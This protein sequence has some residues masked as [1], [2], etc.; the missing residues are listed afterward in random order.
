MEADYK[1]FED[2]NAVTCEGMP[3]AEASARR[4]RESCALWVWNDDYYENEQLTRAIIAQAKEE[5]F[6][7]WGL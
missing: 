5:G 3:Q 1:K 7:A 6:F 2:P 4:Q